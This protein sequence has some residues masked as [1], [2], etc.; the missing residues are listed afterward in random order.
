MPRQTKKIGIIVALV[1]VLIV[2]A[3]TY[4]FYNNYRKNKPDLI[5]RGIVVNFYEKNEYLGMAGDKPYYNKMKYY[6]IKTEKIIQGFAKTQPVCFRTYGDYNFD[7]GVL[8]GS[9]Y[10]I[11][12]TDTFSLKWWAYDIN[13]EHYEFYAP[14]DV[15]TKN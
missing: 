7:A 9:K 13:N 3:L 4:H 5:I 10:N 11:G 15:G 6:C 1:F 8:D 2:G 14:I 12:E